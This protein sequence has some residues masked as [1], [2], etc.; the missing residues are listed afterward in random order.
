MSPTTKLLF[1]SKNYSLPTETVSTLNAPFPYAAQDPKPISQHLFSNQGVRIQL[2]RY[3]KRVVQSW[4]ILCAASDCPRD[5]KRHI[6]TRRFPH[7][8][9]CS[10]TKNFNHHFIKKWRCSPTRTRSSRRDPDILTD[11]RRRVR[12][13]N[14]L[15]V[16]MATLNL[17]IHVR[18]VQV[19]IAGHN[20]SSICTISCLVK[21]DGVKICCGLL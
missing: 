18:I 14:N 16:Q 20:I 9:L 8:Q 12:G 2:T 21:A 6:I 11:N 10:N 19:G 3:Q 7:S 13:T 15:L 5:G 4:N 17:T 1:S